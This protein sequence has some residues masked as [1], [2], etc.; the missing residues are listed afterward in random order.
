MDAV[1]PVGKLITG[2]EDGIVC[3]RRA[4][5]DVIW[6]VAPLSRIHNLAMYELE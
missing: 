2:D 6:S 5:S 4:R 3:E 1:T